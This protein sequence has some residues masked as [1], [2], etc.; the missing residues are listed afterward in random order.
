MQTK[1]GLFY[2]VLSTLGYGSTAVLVLK[3]YQGGASPWQLLL[4]QYIFTLG[5]VLFFLL[6]R[7][8]KLAGVK[9]F[10]PY[11]IINGVIG[12]SGMSICYTLALQH[13]SGSVATLIFFTYPIMVAMGSRLVF[14]EAFTANKA[15]ALV[16]ATLGV[17]F[18]SGILE[19]AVTGTN[20][21][22]I[23]L[24]FASALLITFLVLVAQKLLRDVEP[25]DVAI[26]QHFFN[27]LTMLLLILGLGFARLGSL[28]EAAWLWGFFLALLTTLLPSFFSLKGIALLGAYTASIIAT[29]EIPLTLGLVFLFLQERLSS[30]QGLGSFL[31]MVSVFVLNARGHT[32]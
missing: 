2:T 16:L 6:V 25:L 8:G 5:L 14:G 23:L 10:L 26:V 17:V 15:L 12:Y 31:I 32:P 22:G 18:T 30:W 11:L 27:T 24:S 9:K 28:P 21:K 19:G 1:L 29:L 3:A 13:I 20:L 7:R 4:A